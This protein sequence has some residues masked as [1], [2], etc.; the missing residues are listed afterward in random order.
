MHK[1]WI[2]SN[3]CCLSVLILLFVAIVPCE[4][5]TY[6]VC[7]SGCTATTFSALFSSVDL[8]P[9]DIV[10]ARADT[11]GGS[12]TFT[13]TIT[14]GANDYG[15]AGHPL[16]IR[17]RAGG[18]ITIDGQH[19]RQS[20]IKIDSGVNDYITFDGFY[21]RNFIYAGV[22]LVG[23]SGD[24]VTGVTI[25]NCDIYQYTTNSSLG[26]TEGI[27]LNWTDGTTLRNNMV[28]TYDGSMPW[29]TD[30]FYFQSSSNIDVDGNTCLNRNDDG[31]GHNDGI[32]LTG[33][34]TSIGNIGSTYNITIRNNTLVHNNTG[35]GNKQLIYL[36]YEVG[37]Y[38]RIYNNAI[39]STS[40]TGS[41]LVSIFNKGYGTQGTTEIYN[42]TIYSNGSSTALVTDNSI[43]YPKIKNNVIFINATGS[44]ALMW[45]QGSVNPGDIDYNIGYKA[46]GGNNYRDSGGYKTFSQWQTAGYDAHGYWGNP[47]FVYTSAY[48]YDLRVQSGSPALDHGVDLSSIFVIDRLSKTRTV[49]F[50]IGAY[51]YPGDA[52][53][54]PQ[55]VRVI[56]GGQP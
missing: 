29:Q 49:P 33:G 37:G 4:A 7:S 18:T 43:P 26:S 2:K 52:L 56:S 51:A 32:Q 27:M 19:T 20:G 35:V 9:D 14:P 31:T 3:V 11:S 21:L 13:E 15:S 41:N 12:K 1:I 24:K 23:S 39:Y 17:T 48:P 34:N 22:W 46:G 5:A 8:G 16:I 25:A 53:M 50:G 42:N 36:E 6:T 38:V 10:E 55:R 47:L 54:P 44:E 45:L 28:Y 30:C 40:A